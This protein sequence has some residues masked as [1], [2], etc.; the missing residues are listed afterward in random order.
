M[1]KPISTENPTLR[2]LASLLAGVIVRIH[3]ANLKNSRRKARV[4]DSRLAIDAI[5]AQYKHSPYG[6]EESDETKRKGRK[7][8]GIRMAR[9]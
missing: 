2:D 1:R 3:S 9:S 7:T 6:G 4:A 8:P 5:P